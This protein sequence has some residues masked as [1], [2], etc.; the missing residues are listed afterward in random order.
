MTDEVLTVAQTKMLERVR[1]AGVLLQNGRARKT[2]EA[3]ERAGLVEYD[4]E[5]VPHWDGRYT[6][7]FTVRPAK[8]E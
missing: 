6:E 4:Y 5:L 2:I 8:D 1:K 7:L 3:L